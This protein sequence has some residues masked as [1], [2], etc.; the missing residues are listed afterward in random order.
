MLPGPIPR[1]IRATT[2]AAVVLVATVAGVVS[3]MHMHQLAERA[4]EGWRSW[5]VPLA[6]DGLMVAASMTMV[7]RKR[8]GMTAGNLAW[9]SIQARR[10]LDAAGFPNAVIVAT[11]DLDEHLIATLKEQGAAIKVWG[12][13]T[14]LVTAFDEPALG[15]VYKLTAVRQPRSPHP[16]A[17]HAKSERGMPN[18]DLASAPPGAGSERS[19]R[20]AAGF[21]VGEQRQE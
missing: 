8:A 6:V 15:G 3:Y 9:L 19:S 20:G 7:V 13:G 10:M 5:L 12:V 4:G 21:A 14:K 17:A 1:A 16:V 11:N 18:A 2:M